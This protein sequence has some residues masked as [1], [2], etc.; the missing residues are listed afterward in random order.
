MGFF[1]FLEASQPCGTTYRL[2]LGCT[3]HPNLAS[4]V[5][6]L[7]RPRPGRASPRRTTGCWRENAVVRLLFNIEPYALRERKLRPEIDS[8]SGATHVGLPRVG[9]GLAPA[10][11]LLF[12]AKGAAD[13]GSRRP[14][15]HVGDAA[16]G[17]CHR[18]KSLRLAHIERKDGGGEAR[19]DGVVQ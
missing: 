17:A 15:V 13:L 9:A 12:A 10:A 18:H 11:R 3:L 5:A 1:L 6:V 19:A 7:S 8:I 14:N 2:G 16:I 4:L